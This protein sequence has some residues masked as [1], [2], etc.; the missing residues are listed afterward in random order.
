MGLVELMSTKAIIV[1]GG[2]SVNH[3]DRRPI[4]STPSYV[5]RRC[6]ISGTYIP[7]EIDHLGLFRRHF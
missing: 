6:L 2:A 7:I 4:S 5:P 1:G 3:P